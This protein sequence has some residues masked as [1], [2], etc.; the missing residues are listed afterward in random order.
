[1]RGCG[2]GLKSYRGVCFKFQE[3]R[4]DRV[5]FDG[6]PHPTRSHPIPQECRRVIG[7]SKLCL[8]LGRFDWGRVKPGET[9]TVRVGK[10]GD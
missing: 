3:E 4:F 6:C 10:Q 7:N 2:G 9:I 8:P 1:M 5:P